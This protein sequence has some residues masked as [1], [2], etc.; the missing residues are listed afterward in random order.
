MFFYY[1][2]TDIYLIRYYLFKFINYKVLSWPS[3]ILSGTVSARFQRF[4][5]GKKW[6]HVNSA[7]VCPKLYLLLL[8]M[9]FYCPTFS[10]TLCNSQP[11]DR[12]NCVITVKFKAI[13][14]QSR[15]PPFV[16]QFLNLHQKLALAQP[17]INR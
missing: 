6:S 9:P 15:F 4:P 2:Y 13:L 10:L 14:I 7:A 12:V 11:F 1:I 8:K 16:S 3:N 5:R 17:L